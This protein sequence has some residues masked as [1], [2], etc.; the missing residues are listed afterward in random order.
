[1]DCY[2]LPSKEEIQ[3]ITNNE[4]KR[5]KLTEIS[6]MDRQSNGSFIVKD[7]IMDTYIVSKLTSNSDDIKKESEIKDIVNNN[8]ELKSL[9]KIDDKMLLIQQQL[10]DIEN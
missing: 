5:L 3:V 2:L 9:K 8:K 7:K 6:I 10:D 4:S 1:M